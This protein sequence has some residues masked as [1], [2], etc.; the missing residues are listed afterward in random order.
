MRIIGGSLKG[1]LIQ[2]PKG[3]TTR[4]TSA[5][6]REAVFNIGQGGWEEARVLDLFCGSG[7]IG[8]EALSRGALSVTFVDSNSS[9]IFALKENLQ[10]LHVSGLILKLDA[11]IALKKLAKEGKVFDIIYADPP[12]EAG[13]K[14]EA[15][16]T[17]YA[18]RLLHAIDKAALLAPGGILFI[19]EGG[20]L[21]T[22]PLAHLQ[23]GRTRFFGK[24]CLY[25]YSAL[26]ET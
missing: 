25:Q 16:L 18:A 5:Q 12:Y 4:P 9:A 6:L 14:K 22:H 11:L 7:A 24:S 20:P 19:E 21:Q 1:H 8:I 13:P 10:R 15:P 26:N 23:E 2:A 17:S 3:Q